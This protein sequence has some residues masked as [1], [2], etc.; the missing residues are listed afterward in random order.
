ME[1]LR[2]TAPEAKV[3]VMDLLPAPED[4]IEFVKAGANG[5]IMKDA[6]VD[7][8]V[9]TIRSVARARTWSPPP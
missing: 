8:L 7:D 3:I 9:S 5:F 4:V 2:K 1:T 6:T